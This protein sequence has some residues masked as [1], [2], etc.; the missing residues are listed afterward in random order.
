M[1]E[2]N[3]QKTFAFVIRKIDDITLVQVI[4]K[5]IPESEVTSLMDGYTQILK[6]KAKKK[7]SDDLGF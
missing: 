5:G 7:V 6:D 3:A 4:G 1:E 2:K